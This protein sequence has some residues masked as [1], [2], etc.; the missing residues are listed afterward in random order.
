MEF[1]PD[2]YKG[3]AAYYDRFRPPYPAFGKQLAW[4]LG[5]FV[6]MIY[7]TIFIRIWT[8]CQGF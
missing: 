7:N 2:L 1:R 3:T 5:A 8:S 6:F 4:I